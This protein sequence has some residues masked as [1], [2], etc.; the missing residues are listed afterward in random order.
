MEQ[1]LETEVALLRLGAEVAPQF[2]SPLV[3]QL[4]A[5]VRRAI[6]GR[7]RQGLRVLPAEVVMDRRSKGSPEAWHPVHAP[8]WLAEASQKRL[9]WPRRAGPWSTG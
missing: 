2:G 9:C 7:R 4:E 3:Q 5:K 8:V 6:A 1:R